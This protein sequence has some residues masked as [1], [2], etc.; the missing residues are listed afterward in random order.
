MRKVREEECLRESLF[1]SP[2]PC[3]LCHQSAHAAC[4]GVCVC[5]DVCVCVCVCVGLSLPLGLILIALYST[6]SLLIV[7]APH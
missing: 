3:S 1:V 6:S 7:Y 2:K 5:V 4:T